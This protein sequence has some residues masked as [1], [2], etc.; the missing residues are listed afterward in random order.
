[1]D[2]ISPHQSHNETTRSHK[3]RQTAA[4]YQNGQVQI[5]FSGRWTRLCLHVH[6]TQCTHNV[7]YAQYINV[8]FWKRGS[9]WLIDRTC[10]FVS[11]GWEGIKLERKLGVQEVKRLWARPDWYRNQFLL[12]WSWQYVWDYGVLCEKNQSLPML[13]RSF[14]QAGLSLEDRIKYKLLWCERY[15]GAI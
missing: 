1:M 11:D 6:C 13:R 5:S 9:R 15:N 2:N 12:A 14:E 10:L 3:S 7:H 4:S 8:L